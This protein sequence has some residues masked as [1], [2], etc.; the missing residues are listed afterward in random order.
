MPVSRIANFPLCQ[1]EMAP[2]L[3][4]GHARLSVS[5]SVISAMLLYLGLALGCQAAL[6]GER[7]AKQWLEKMS[8]AMQ[9]LSYRGVFIYRRD[10]DLAAMKVTHIVDKHGARELLETLTGEARREMRSTPVVAGDNPTVSQLGGIDRYYT[11]EL[12]GSDRTAGHAT[13]VI[14][15]MP[16]DEYR[17][18]YRL[19]L[20]QSTGLLLKSDLL[21]QDGVIL[22]QVMFTSLEVLEPD[23]VGEISPA[24]ES[25]A[26]QHPRRESPT[27]QAVPQWTVEQLP[28]GFELLESQPM[29]EH[30]NV[31]HLVYSDGL[32][33]VSVFVER[34]KPEGEAFVGLSR[35]GAVNAY[36]SVEDGYQVTVVGEVP[37]ITVKSMGRSIKRKG[38]TQ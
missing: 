18:G 11:L 21:A 6:A 23:E 35:M 8:A 10:T 27:Q 16:R 25:R 37:E 38:Q 32:A 15:V 17:Y 31:L 3:I 36:G 5:G 24:E 20:D 26:A 9:E 1:R 4:P 28:G 13:K 30:K 29:T 12:L 2:A 14:S 22:E 19:W 7:S 34:A 33:S